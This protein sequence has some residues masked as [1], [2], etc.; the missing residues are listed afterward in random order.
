[1][2]DAEQPIAHHIVFLE[3]DSIRGQVRRPAFPHRWT[4]YPLSPP[5]QV[6]ARLHDATVAITNK[7]VLRGELLARL[8]QLRMIAVAATGTDN[9]DLAWCQANGIVVSNIRGYAVDT[10]PEHVLMLALMLK[11]RV[12]HYRRD[13]Q[14]G[15]WQQASMFCFFDHPIGDLCGGTIGICG[16]GSLGQGVARRAEAFGMRVLWAERKGAAQIRPGYTAFDA[17]LREADVLTLHLPLNDATRN[18]IGEAELGQMKRDAVLINTA[19]GGLVDEPALARALREG[20]ILGAGLDVLSKEP[21]REG[22]V[23]LAPALLEAPNF[24][25][26]PHVAWASARAM[27]ALLDQLIDN[28]EAYATGSPRNRV[29]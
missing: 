18:L 10:V 6:E 7:V 12:L 27:Q 19:R 11:R 3:R 15:K 29:A 22:N 28:I 16:R 4:E 23:L 5:D 2:S 25:L 14:Q 17:V 13:V 8:P 1:M 26:T 20:R 9:V 21:P 24:V